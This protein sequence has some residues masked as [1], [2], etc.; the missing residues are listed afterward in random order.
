MN[1]KTPTVVR[2]LSA[3]SIDDQALADRIRGRQ[4]DVHAS[5]KDG[6]S[7][8]HIAAKRGLLQ[9]CGALL[10]AGCDV[11]QVSALHA[12]PLG[13]AI[14]KGAPLSVIGLLIDRGATLVSAHPLIGVPLAIALQCL[15]IDVAKALIERGAD[16]FYKGH[17]GTYL[18]QAAS[19]GR[20]DVCNEVLTWGIDL[21][22]RNVMGQTALAEAVFQRN[23]DVARAFL[24]AGANPDAPD[25]Q[26]ETPRM[27][28]ARCGSEAMR[29]L[30]SS[31]PGASAS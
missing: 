12:Q 2:C 16:P 27:Y 17:A 20:V 3:T 19:L 26:G 23:V 31:Q 25:I 14:S 29:A 30:F 6:Q 18:H 1:R 11:N 24:L 9:T 10:D 21:E 22:L 5:S 4:L 7:A 28:A 13:L 15:R 8:L